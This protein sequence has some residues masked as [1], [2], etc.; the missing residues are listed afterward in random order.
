MVGRYQGACAN[1]QI[2]RTTKFLP[3]VLTL[4]VVLAAEGTTSALNPSKQQ[5]STAVH[6]DLGRPASIF[7][8]DIQFY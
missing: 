8:S 2:M 1:G 6:G 7:D 4:V 3:N 5:G